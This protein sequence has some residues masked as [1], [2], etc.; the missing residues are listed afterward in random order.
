MGDAPVPDDLSIANQLGE[1]YR[2]VPEENI[3]LTQK[4]AIYIVLTTLMPDAGFTFGGIWAVA[5]A[6]ETRFRDGPAAR[7][8]LVAAYVRL[9]DALVP[10]DVE[11]IELPRREGVAVYRVRTWL[12]RQ[13]LGQHDLEIAT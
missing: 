7:G 11:T 8:A 13:L 10:V 5:R 2:Y 6:E 12:D 3:N 4:S 9:A 1:H